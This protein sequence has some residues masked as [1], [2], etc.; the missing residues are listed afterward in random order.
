MGKPPGLTELRR[1][2][3][4]PLV[5]R[6]G[7]AAPW[8]NHGAQAAPPRAGLPVREQHR[9]RRKHVL[10]ALKIVFH[11]SLFIAKLHV[12]TNLQGIAS[13]NF[14]HEL[15]GLCRINID[16]ITLTRTSPQQTRSKGARHISFQMFYLVKL[17]LLEN[18][19]T[20]YLVCV[21][22][23]YL[24]SQEGLKQHF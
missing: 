3:P 10:C 7:R 11:V 9:A 16:T 14:L 13:C 1:C 8:R 5:Q 20:L 19:I 6:G 17:K 18:V 15:A 4:Q 23:M 12:L 24:H 21:Y 2:A 22:W